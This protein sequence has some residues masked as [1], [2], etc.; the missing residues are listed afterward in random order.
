MRRPLSRIALVLTT[1]G[2][3]C[4]PAL[5]DDSAQSTPQTPASTPSPTTPPEA[6]TTPATSTAPE[7][8]IA[9]ATPAP[10]AQQP[11]QTSPPPPQPAQTS[12]PAAPAPPKPAPP[13]PVQIKVNDNVNFRFGTLLQ[14]QADFSQ[15]S[16]GGYAQN[17]FLRRVRF[18]VSGQM[19]K[20]IYFF[21]QTENSRLGLP[22]AAGTKTLGAGFQT[23]DALAEWRFSKP[24]NLWVGLI[25]LPTSREALKASGSEF[26]IDTNTYT[27]T[28]TTALA[29][30]GGRDTGFMARGY[31]LAD[32]LEYRAGLFQGLR[33]TGSRNPM[34]KI[35]RLQYNVFDTELYNMPSYPGSYFGTKKILALGA[36]YDN[37]EG[38]RG[39]TADVYADFP[40]LF[41]SAV[42]TATYQRLDGGKFLTALP[43]SNTFVVDGG[44]FFK[45]SK[46]GPWAR[47]EKRDFATPNS[48]KNEKRA[49]L[50]LNYYFAGNNFN[51]KAAFGRLS[52]VV[53]RK[54]NQFTVQMQ[55]FLY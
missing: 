20:Q 25:Y 6:T 43:E 21:F 5:A 14:P 28:A 46:L 37:Q 48:S 22:N 49:L 54:T 44:V 19:A 4:L 45:G 42:G 8:T 40:T 35:A 12:P 33:E 26:M 29:G 52:P 23:I 18:I 2:L 39:H 17:L 30:T 24:L 53:G 9:Q 36:A 55:A 11:A 51:I 13:G 41:G 34:R 32:H 10:A 1:A 31:F 15:G 38:Y 50:G 16:T 27:Y 47:Y 7:A 3:L